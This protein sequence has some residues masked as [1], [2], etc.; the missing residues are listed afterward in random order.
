V[1]PVRRDR[2]RLESAAISHRDGF[3]STKRIRLGDEIAWRRERCVEENAFGVEVEDPRTE[4]VA[5]PQVAVAS[6]LKGF[7]VDVRSGQQTLW[8]VPVDDRERQ[9]SVGIPER[10]EASVVGVTVVGDSSTPTTCGLEVGREVVRPDQEVSGVR[11]VAESVVGHR[12]VLARRPTGD[13]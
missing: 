13:D 9:Q 8:R 11:L 4:L 7:G 3:R 6:S 2:H 10:D 1:L 12:Q 5:H